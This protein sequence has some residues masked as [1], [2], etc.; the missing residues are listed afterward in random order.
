M[1]YRN[2]SVEN[3]ASNESFIDWVNKSDPEAVRHWDLY[4]SSHPEIKPTVDKARAL[5]LNLKAAEETGR[6]GAQIS[7]IW[8]RIQSRVQAEEKVLKA[9]PSKSRWVVALTAIVL[10]CAV[11]AFWFFYPPAGS[12]RESGYY[13]QKLSEFVEQVNESEQPMTVTLSD[14][15][16][17]MLDGKSRLKYKHTFLQDSSRQVYLLGKAY[18]D[19]MK[20]PYKPFIVH[21]N[22]IDVKVLGTSFRV[23]SPEHGDK[24]LVSVK[25]GK[26]SVFAV[27]QGEQDQ[28][29]PGGIVLLPNQQVTYARKER[30]FQKSLVESPELLKTNTITPGD[31]VF[32]N[33]PIADV[34]RIIES[35]YGVEI[36]FN[37]E[38][39]KN[40]YLTAPLGNES[41]HDKL[42]IICATIG[43]TY[44]IIDANIVVTSPGCP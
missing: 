42:K 21:S 5:I 30:L 3:L 18:F 36:I 16:V 26:V 23:E 41:L 10:F 8:N 43:A 25:T 15:T 1:D 19:V 28:Q 38:V 2:L 34:F 33:A 14:G 4:I 13:Q 44:E 22:E 32:D 29:K 11:S 31:F 9:P 20:N 17:V 12:K 35:A 39:M 24:I 6:D 27:S 37:E 7:S 40:C